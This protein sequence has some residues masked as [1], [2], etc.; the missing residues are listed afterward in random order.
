M[1][2]VALFVLLAVLVPIA[3]GIAAGVIMKPRQPWKDTFEVAAAGS[4]VVAVLLLLVI[5]VGLLAEPSMCNH[6]GCNDSDN[7]AAVQ[8]ILVVPLLVPIYGLVLIGAAIGKLLGR[9]VR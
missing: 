7:A 6:T 3:V 1:S 9:S 8:A 2:D 5:V 4:G